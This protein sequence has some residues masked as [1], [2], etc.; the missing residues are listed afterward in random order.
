MKSPLLLAAVLCGALGISYGASSAPSPHLYKPLPAKIEAENYDAML[1]VQTETTSDVGGGL[2]VSWIDDNDWMD[3]QVNVPSAGVYAFSFRVANSYGNGKIE[4]QNASGSVLSTLS[5]PQTGGWQGWT[6]I[7]TSVSLPAGNQTIRIFARQGAW[8]FNW[9][10]VKAC[11]PIPAK[12][13]AEDYDAMLGVQTETTS[14]VGGG[15]NVG[16]IDSND[17]LDYNIKVP[18]AGNYT[19]NFRIA[20]SYG[21]GKFEVQNGNGT[22]LKTISVPQT[23]GWQVWSTITTTVALPEGSQKL[24]LFIK[25]GD[26]NF[27]W[28]EIK[29]GTSNS[30]LSPSVVSFPAIPEKKV[31]DQ[32]FVLNATS[33]NNESPITYT[34]ANPDIISVSNATGQWKA[35]VVAAGTTSI[36]A[37]Q[38]A[39]KNYTAAGNETV[40]VLVKAN[41]T[42]P[43]SPST[44]TPAYEV[45]GTKITL[46]PK[47]WYQLN[48]VSNG[49]EGLF[50]GITDVAVNTGWG[51]ILNNFDAYYP[52]QDGERMTI[53]SIRFYDGEGSLKDNPVT[54]S[55][56]D[57]NW[58]RIPIA[59]FTGER[60]NEWVGPYPDRYSTFTLDTPIPNARYLVLNAWYQY[61]NEMEIYGTYQA[62][63]NQPT[64]APQKS[65]KLKD[66]FGINAFE[67]D[68]EDGQNPTVINETKLKAVKNFS[69]IRHY[70]D[71]EKLESTE[72]KYTFN[73][74]HSGGWNYDIIYERCKAEGIEVLACLK[75]IPNWMQETYPDD[76]RDSE[77]IPLRYGKDLTNPTSYIEQAKVGFQYAARYGSNTNVDPSLMSVNSSQRWNN[78]GINTVKIGLNLIKYIECENE[79]DKWWKGRKAYQTSR[80]YAAN[81]SAFYDGHKNTMGPGVGIKN[82]DPNMKVVVAGLAAASVDYIKGM[83]DWCKEYRGYKADGSVNLCWDVIN[84]HLYSDDGAMMQN[85]MASRG[86]APE[87]TR[88]RQIASDFNTLAHQQSQ[89]MPVWVTETGYDL[90]QGSPLKAIAIGNKTAI[91][92]QADWILRTSLLYARAGIEKVFLYQMYDDNF[93]SPTQFGSMGL[94]NTDQTRKPAADYIHQV[95]EKFGEFSY[96]STLQN[97]PIVD[98]YKY[99]NQS[100]YMLVVP[101]EKERTASYVLNLN[102]ASTAK[103]YKPVIGSDSMQVTT[104]TATAG[105]VTIPVSETPV[106]VVPGPTTSTA[107]R[108]AAEAAAPVLSSS[109]SSLKVFPV[110]AV[111]FVEV[112]LENDNALPVEFYL[113]DSGLGRS[114]K[115]QLH[116][117]EGYSF[118]QKLD[119]SSLNKG[120]Y[121]LEI[122]QGQER[123]IKKFVKM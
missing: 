12:I 38:A 99:N 20:N 16:R 117:K 46:D 32:P 65:V 54:I 3:Y 80:E 1:G 96:Q 92:T 94:I 42:A 83:I 7:S 22:V 52:L 74:V 37:S 61:P 6:T 27:N 28:L 35:N 102:G 98:H 23:G 75:T 4:L 11:R 120:V 85:G 58:K 63:T 70:M 107:G 5:V 14:D 44:T 19:L 76:E 50:D 43:T 69:G 77:N 24:R 86:A 108:V 53:Q 67:W 60:Y 106:F 72:G 95:H 62:A 93:L 17:W 41:Q 113:Y 66:M 104:L 21:N 109:L 33:N 10:E 84:Y 56:I 68:F 81:L 55:I 57:E 100:M 26:W 2:N 9:F 71:W 49:L 45:V 59:T 119:V 30:V 73:P 87:V 51:K 34:S 111:D 39:S 114:I 29:T 89:G 105:K 97:D 121:L 116:K 118:H 18:S 36:T 8:N 110:P 13:E 78:D 25:Q 101:D 31:G 103:L 82:A 79:R 40:N 64:A 91:Q 47:R 112:S 115:Q 123:V 88:V 122:R 15:L 90:N 48:N